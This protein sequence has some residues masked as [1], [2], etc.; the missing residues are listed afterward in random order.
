MWSDQVSRYFSI[1]NVKQ[2]FGIEIEIEGSSVRFPPPAGWSYHD[3]NSLRNGGAEY[4]S[5]PMDLKSIEPMVLSLRAALGRARINEASHR[6]GVHIHRNC[7]YMRMID[8]LVI[9]AVYYCY[10]PFMLKMLGSHRNG[11]LFC[12]PSYDIGDNNRWFNQLLSCVFSGGYDWPERGRYCSCN[13]DSLRRY[14]TVE[15]RVFPFSLDGAE[16]ATWARW[17]DKFVEDA[18]MIVENRSYLDYLKIIQKDP[19]ES[20]IKIFGQRGA[21]SISAFGTDLSKKLLDFGV[22]QAYEYLRPI[23]KQVSRTDNRHKKPEKLVKKPLRPDTRDQTPQPGWATVTPE[24][25]FTDILNRTRP[26]RARPVR[27]N[28]QIIDDVVPTDNQF[29]TPPDDEF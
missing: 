10:E 7:T 29:N 21:S 15:W 18:L 12:M 6:A 5:Q 13:L 28:L 4:V 23:Q 22:E 20:L 27:E 11:N 26:G 19:I 16:I 9:M 8:P 2:N 24:I 17:I 14:G 1:A 3:E 25:N